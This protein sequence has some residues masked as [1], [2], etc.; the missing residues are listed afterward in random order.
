MLMQGIG[1][2]LHD[3]K[4]DVVHCHDLISPTLVSAAFHK[5]SLNY[6]LF[7]DSITGTYNPT[8]IR[9]IAFLLYKQLAFRYANRKIDRFFAISVGSQKW[10]SEE[11]DVSCQ[12]IN[13]EP[14]GADKDLFKSNS[15]K[16]KELRLS[17]GFSED[18]I[19]IVYSGKMIPEK[20]LD[21][22]VSAVS[23][24][25]SEL[26][27]KVRILFVGNGPKNYLNNISKLAMCYG[28]L[29]NI[30]FHPPVNR[31][32]LP[33]YYSAADIGVWPGSPSNSIIEA[34]STGL[35]IVIAGYDPPRHDAYDTSNL[36][37]YGNGFSFLRGD[38]K[39]LMSCIE[40]LVRDDRLRRSMGYRGRKLVEERLNWDTIADHTLNVYHSYRERTIG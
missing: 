26:K 31:K 23:F 4:P 35:P 13:V 6:S 20:D 1:K 39:E 27:R 28:V 22:L 30:V 25:P 2:V 14:L 5:K 21:I 8:T 33:E 29:E 16:R 37:V 24:L 19:V 18:V 3:F 38:S 7:V 10:L 32:L 9:K 15:I 34:I 36:L 40:K 11:L 17:L 12:D